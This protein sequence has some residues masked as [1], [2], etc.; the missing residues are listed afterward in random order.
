MHLFGV[1]GFSQTLIQ[2]LNDCSAKFSSFDIL[3][4]ES[5]RQGWLSPLSVAILRILLARFLA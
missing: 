1:V 4:D 2:I 5:V 3:A